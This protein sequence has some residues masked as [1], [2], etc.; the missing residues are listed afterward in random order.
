[1]PDAISQLINM[2]RVRSTAYLSKNLRSAW[3]VDV[4]RYQTLARF[5]LIIDGQT[6][7]GLPQGRAP[8][9]LS[10]GDIAIIPRGLPH[11]YFDGQHSPEFT[12]G[13]YPYT[14]EEPIFQ[15]LYPDRNDTHMICGYFEFSAETPATII[16]QMPDILI[17]SP[18]ST[19]NTKQF[20]AVAD[21]AFEELAARSSGFQVRLNRLTEILCVQTIQD[22]LESA[23][24]ENAYLRALSDPRTLLVMNALH[25]DPDRNWTVADLAA[26]YGQSRSAFTTR[27][28]LATGQSPMLYLRNHRLTRARQM[29]ANGALSID[30]IA[31][32]SGY[33]DTNAFNRA[34]KRA[35]SISP[36]QYRRGTRD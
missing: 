27:F 33:A 8:Q 11:S 1:M 22:W 35:V 31:F 28:K 10:A 29:L 6:W 13:N 25:E 14:E 21:M 17:G 32:K 36:G 12:P 7:I 23:A 30:E 3:A 26:L 9:L 19:Q 4:Q 16:E 18:K 24:F 20:R 2:M 15:P 5:H 34:F